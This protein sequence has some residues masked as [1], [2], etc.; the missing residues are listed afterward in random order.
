MNANR[1]RGCSERVWTTLLFN[2]SDQWRFAPTGVFTAPV[3]GV[4]YFTIFHH[5]GGEHAAKLLLYKNH[6]RVIMT[7]NHRGKH[8]TAFNGGN[9]VFL[10]V[11]KG[12]QVFVRMAENT[13]V[14]GS[15]HHTTFSGYLVKQ[16]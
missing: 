9:A 10:E 2:T 7:Q 5:C 3:A 12:D 8:E 4:Y 15:N 14:W 1:F 6:N 16:K 11:Q 13:H